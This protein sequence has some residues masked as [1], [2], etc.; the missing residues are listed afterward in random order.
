MSTAALMDKVKREQSDIVAV[1]RDLVRIPSEN[2]PGDTTKVFDFAADLLRR[3]GYKP[4]LLKPAP[5]RQNL[6]VSWDSGR[7]GK[8]LAFNG[9]LDVFPAGDRARWARD[10]YSGDVEKGRLYGRGVT[11]MKGGVTASL[12][13]FKYLREMEGQLAGKATL[14][15]VCDEETFAEFGARHLVANYPEVLGDALINGEP[16]TP[17]IMRIGDKGPRVVG[18]DLSHPGRPRRLRAPERERRPPR[19]AIP[20]GDQGHR[21]LAVAAARG[22]LPPPPHHR[23]RDG[24]ERRQGRH[25]AGSPLRRGRST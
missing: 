7:P 10:P 8:H 3:W 20:P 9:H 22:A 23:G 17:S 13:A 2:P 15:L 6:I 12:F 16:S 18:G 11:D 4:R 1:C 24:Q 19:H 5:K 25:R 21:A 14:S